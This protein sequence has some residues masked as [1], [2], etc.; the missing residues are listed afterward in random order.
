[1]APTDMSLID[2]LPVERD[3]LKAEGDKAH[4]DCN[5][6]NQMID[7]LR[8]ERDALK[9]K[10]ELLRESLA[11]ETHDSERYS[12]RIDVVALRAQVVRLKGE[13]DL[14][15]R[16][17]RLWR[18][19]F[20]MVDRQQEELTTELCHKCLAAYGAVLE[21]NKADAVACPECGET[22]CG[23]PRRSREVN[24]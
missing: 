16:R 8:A 4:A 1:M 14:R 5:T 2:E 19:S 17:E 10:V 6:L 15:L 12:R 13:V 7:D 22:L 3:A 11:A 23:C 18:R 9:A 24:E 21:N 20:A